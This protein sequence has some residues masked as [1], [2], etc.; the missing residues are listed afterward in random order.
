MTLSG[1]A[2]VK[3]DIILLRDEDKHAFLLRGQRFAK[4]ED[5]AD[6]WAN[7]RRFRLLKMAN[8]ARGLLGMS[9]L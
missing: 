1:L 9:N 6:F 4:I 3:Q 8:E 2:G 7:I 5:I